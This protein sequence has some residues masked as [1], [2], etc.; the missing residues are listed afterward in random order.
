MPWLTRIELN[1]TNRTVRSELR[2]AV[3]MHQ[4]LMTLMPAALGDSPRQQAGLLYRIDEN[5]TGTQILIQ[6][7]HEPDL[8]AIPATY[9][10][11][12]VRDLTPLLDA[13][14]HDVL[15]HYRLAGSAIKRLARGNPHPG[16][17]VALRGEEIDQ[18]WATRAPAC[19]LRLETLSATP[20]GHIRGRRP[21]AQPRDQVRH[22][23][24]RFEGIAAVTD[25]DTLRQAV[26][27]GI[28]RGKS[29]GCGLLSLALAR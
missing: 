27:E 8:T 19:G 16:K 3:T 18:W 15:V 20:Q 23:I 28:G 5:R 11:A 24:A 14:D 13:L 1:L 6:S 25:P 17:V 21:D 9:G 29:H 2:N 26:R 12:A 22:A 7:Q 4:R 10:T